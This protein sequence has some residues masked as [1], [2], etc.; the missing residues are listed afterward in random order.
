MPTILADDPGHLI[1]DEPD[2][3]ASRGLP[4]FI[5][6][7]DLPNLVFNVHIYCGARSP[8]TGNP[9]NAAACAAQDE[10]SLGVR[11]SDRPEM[12]SATQ[13]GGPAWFVTEFGATSDP[14][15][16]AS[17]TAAM[18]AQQVGWAYWAWKYYGDPT[19]SAAESLVM[20]D[21]RLRST[22]RVLSRA[23]PQA[24]AGTP[25]SF[26]FS[27][28]TDVFDMAYVPNHRIHAPTLIFVPTELHY[29]H[30]YCA[31]ITGGAGDVGAGG[32]TCS[33]CRTPASGTASP[34]WSRRGAA[35]RRA[36]R[37]PGIG[38]RHVP[39]HHHPA[40]ARARGH[41]RRDRG[42]G[43]PVRPQGQRRADDVAP[44]RGG[45]RARRRP[46]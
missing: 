19:G 35:R 18:D 39:Q 22:A 17:I 12:A 37:D 2:N 5:G 11:A 32:A 21:G 40:R 45:V 41:T 15:L 16:L 20:A 24:V 43:A 1:F 6:P 4:T 13:P 46:R 9:T 14:Q 8:V 27:P 38:W 7:M 10:H 31:R 30:G 44:D 36:R 23:Y 28:S 34:W 33:R 42:G 26:T 29:P 25:L 3:Y